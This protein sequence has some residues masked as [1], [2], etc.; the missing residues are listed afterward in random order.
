MT[1][2]AFSG[3]RDRVAQQVEDPDL[4]Y[5]SADEIDGYLA[6]AQRRYARRTKCL[7]GETVLARRENTQTYTMPDDYLEFLRMEDDEG[8]EVL[9]CSW[10]DLYERYGSDF[11]DTTGD[12]RYVYADLDGAGGFRFYPD[13][14]E[15]LLA[16]PTEPTTVFGSPLDTAFMHE[17]GTDAATRDSAGEIHCMD[18]AGG[19]ILVVTSHRY[20]FFHGSI[21]ADNLMASYTCQAV[22]GLAPGSDLNLDSYTASARIDLANGRCFVAYNKSLVYFDIATGSRTTLGNAES[23][24]TY[25]FPIPESGPPDDRIVYTTDTGDKLMYWEIGTGETE[26]ESGVSVTQAV[27]LSPAWYYAVG[28]AVRQLLPSLS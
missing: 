23:E 14:G 1:V 21:A 13:P 4:Q 27:W 7:R 12:P 16:T 24:V 19:I 20:W 10:R 3:L 2:A 17:C 22:H 8:G 11:R 15:S 26:I 28:D 6:E 9:P 25:M 5:Y 18:A